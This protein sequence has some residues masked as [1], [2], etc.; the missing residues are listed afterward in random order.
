[1]ARS[2]TRNGHLE[3]TPAEAITTFYGA[4]LCQFLRVQLIFLECDS[5]V[6]INALVS[7]NCNG[8]KFGHIVDD[9]RVML[10][11]FSQWKC[12]HVRR[13]VDRVAQYLT[14]VATKYVMDRTWWNEILNCITDIVRLE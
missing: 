1:M 8:S 10:N 6:V 13:D 2:L 11:S 5:L 4:S 7:T 14:K 3:P 9:L 12:G